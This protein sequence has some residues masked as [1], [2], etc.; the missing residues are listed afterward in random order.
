MI[1]SQSKK[2]LCVHTLL[3][4]RISSSSLFHPLPFVCSPPCIRQKL[5]VSQN[6]H[7]AAF[8]CSPFCS[9]GFFSAQPKG[10]SPSNPSSR[11]EAYPFL[12]CSTVGCLRLHAELGCS[13]VSKRFFKKHLAYTSPTWGSKRK[14]LEV[15]K[16]TC[17][18]YPSHT[19]SQ[20]SAMLISSE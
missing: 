13:A 1:L 8:P 11:A 5:P 9:S 12:L 2:H 14:Y 15:V 6:E 17:L 18:T 7:K 4:L 10:C 19:S 16:V 20:L 3:Q